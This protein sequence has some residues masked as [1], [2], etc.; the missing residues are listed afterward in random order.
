[1]PC[2]DDRARATLEHGTGGA[3]PSDS[4]TA[5]DAGVGVRKRRAPPVTDTGP[6]VPGSGSGQ[7]IWVRSNGWNGP[8]KAGQPDSRIGSERLL[9]W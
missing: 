2:Y 9:W 8:A 4:A 5:P 3:V 6:P 7:V 1:M